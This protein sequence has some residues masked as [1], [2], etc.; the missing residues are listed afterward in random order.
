MAGKAL[1][2]RA[3]K[4]KRRANLVARGVDDEEMLD[5]MTAAIGL[6]GQPFYVNGIKGKKVAKLPGDMQVRVSL[7]ERDACAAIPFVTVDCIVL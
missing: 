3:A 1:A 4:L 7:A 5:E 6:P 2:G